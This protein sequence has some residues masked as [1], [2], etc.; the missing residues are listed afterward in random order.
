[1]NDQEYIKLSEIREELANAK[2]HRFCNTISYSHFECMVAMMDR[3][4][5]K[6][7]YSITCS[8]CMLKLMTKVMNM[9]EQYEEKLKEKIVVVEKSVNT[10]KAVS[11]V[12]VKNN[13]K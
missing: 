10:T 1:M 13:K 7:S 2:Y 4:S 6:E 12:V 5:F 3:I 11:K 8:S 9:L